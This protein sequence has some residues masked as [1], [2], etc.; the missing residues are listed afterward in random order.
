MKLNSVS[1]CAIA[2]AACALL[3]SR[4][5]SAQVVYTNDFEATSAWNVNTGPATTDSFVDTSFDYSAVGIP[6]APGGSGTRGLKAYANHSASVFGG[7]SASPTGQSFSG[8]YV[9]NFDMWANVN[10]P[11]PAGGSG[12][13]M[14]ATMGL[15]T[16]GTSPQWAGGVQDSIWFAATGDGNSSVDWRAY[17]PAASTGYTAPSG[18]FAAGTGTSP[19]ARNQSHPY[20]A[21][22]GGNTAPAAQ[23]TLYAQQTGTTLVGAAGMEWLPVEIRKSGG[24]V[25]WTVQGTLIATVLVSADTVNTG[26]NIFLGHGDTNTGSSGDANDAALLFSVYDNLSVT[27]IPEPTTLGLLAGAGVLALRRRK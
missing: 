14:L 19:D 15:D 27:L 11:F 8:D 13:T 20:Y 25:T 17:S 21:S 2:L 6:A 1:A 26:N 16:S 5:A 12:S 7:V 9:V 24:V 4:Q 22:F 23:T 3:D 10:G 18:V